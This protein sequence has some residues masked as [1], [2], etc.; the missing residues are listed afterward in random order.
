MAAKPRTGRRRIE[1]ERDGASRSRASPWTTGDRLMSTLNGD[2]RA[3]LRLCGAFALAASMGSRAA[4]AQSGVRSARSGST[5]RP[6]AP[7]AGDPTATWVEQEL[8][9]QLAQAL[10]GRLTPKGATLTVRIDSLTLGPNKDSRAW[11]NISGVATVGGVAR[12]VRA[13]SRIGLRRSMRRRSCNPITPVFR[14]PR[15][16]W[17]S[18][19][20]E[21]SDPACRAAPF[22]SVGLV[23]GNSPVAGPASDGPASCRP[24]T[25]AT[26][27]PGA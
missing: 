13:T 25:S 8:P 24:F 1:K 27:T 12:P 5:L 14:R 19:L 6:C 21:I 15:R 11:D 20:P 22:S 17:R 9:R 2:R 4:L 3:R 18:G 16:R 7:T 26:I 10:S 23:A